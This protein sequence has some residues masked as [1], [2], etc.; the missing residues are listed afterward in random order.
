MAIAT[1][2]LAV[3]GISSQASAFTPRVPQVPVLG[4]TLQGYLNGQG[5]SINVLTDQQDA[6]VWSQSAS[7]NGAITLMVELTGNAGSNTYGLYN[8]LNPA[9]PLYQIFPGAATAGWFAVMS[10]RTAPTRVVINLFDAS[11]TLQ[12]TT[13]Y[14]GIDAN[15]F[16]FYEQNLNT[17]QTL[18]SQ[19]GRNPG[20]AAQMLA[21]QGTGLNAGEWWLCFEDT[22]LAASD[23][24]FDDAVMVLES[25]NPLATVP[26][27][28]GSVKALYRK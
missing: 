17:G 21:Y 14:L 16:G 5:E 20:A 11:A 1:A 19:D 8:A 12:G 4:G 26:A 27:T 3:L 13:V 25:V 18:Y 6:Q 9:P 7:G 10:F 22:P 28:L 2:S 24:D 15:S 23:Q